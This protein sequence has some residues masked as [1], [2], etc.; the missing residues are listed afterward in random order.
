M[1]FLVMLLVCGLPT[2]DTVLT[3]EVDVIELNHFVV[4]SPEKDEVVRRF[5]QFIFWDDCRCKQDGCCGRRV[6]AW[7]L[8]ENIRNF[9]SKVGSQY[10]MIFRD[11]NKLRDIRA[12][13]FR[14]TI[15]QATENLPVPSMTMDPERIDRRVHKDRKELLTR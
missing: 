3:E 6:V 12:P 13:L 9:P 11:K 1:L 2:S 14:E 15:I 7:R 10:R 4:Y 5:S 8:A